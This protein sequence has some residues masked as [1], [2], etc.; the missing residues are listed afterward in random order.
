MKNM[1]LNTRRRK[2][3]AAGGLASAIGISLYY[4]NTTRS[5]MHM[6]IREMPV[7]YA[8][9]TTIAKR[10]STKKTKSI[11]IKNAIFS[12]RFDEFSCEDT[13]FSNCIFTPDSLIYIKN[14]T[15]V[16]FESCNFN[17]SQLSGGIWEN[18]EFNECIANGE[19]LIFADKLS[20]NVVFDNCDFSGPASTSQA[21]DENI[22]GAVGSL[23]TVVFQKCNLSRV[24][25]R[26]EISITVKN[27]HLSKVSAETMREKGK[28]YFEKV[29]VSDYIDFTKGIFTEFSIKDSLFDFMNLE[30][31]KSDSIVIDGCSGHLVAQFLH[32]N[33]V[34]LR[35]STFTAN[36][37]VKNPFQN[38]F[39]ALSFHASTV[40]N[41]VLDDIKFS[42]IN[43]TPYFGGSQNLTYDKNDPQS[44]RF[45]SSEFKKISIHKTL[46]KNLF[47]GYAKAD[48]LEILNSEIENANFIDSRL[49]KVIFSGILLKGTIDFSGAYVEEFVKNSVRTA[50]D[51]NLKSDMNDTINI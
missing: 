23:G 42:G 40:E 6:S 37:E 46:L 14:L 30:Y 32:S 44:K 29:T 5:I 47:L 48:E 22:L 28:L 35:N 13:I 9:L 43:G 8:F 19:F 36:G 15:N 24:N 1:N 33:T 34:A 18:V 26:G 16:K 10:R 51:I 21:I 50:S 11:I 3:I 31:C 38:T 20:Q 25:I 12:E 49:K 39:S 2:L 41:L 45:D 17:H 27:S 7:E 4:R